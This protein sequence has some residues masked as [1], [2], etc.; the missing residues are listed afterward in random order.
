MW[1]TPC[2]RLRHARQARDS[3]HAAATPPPSA[4]AG[5]LPALQAFPR[6]RAL[7]A[8]RRAAGPGGGG[9]PLGRRAA[10]FGLLPGW[11]G[12]LLLGA[13]PGRVGRRRRRLRLGAG[14]A[15]GGGLHWVGLELGVGGVQR[16][17]AACV[18]VELARAPCGLEH[19]KHKKA[20]CVYVREHVRAM[21][22]VLVRASS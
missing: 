9:R 13:L 16:A 14:G 20:T 3:R 2:S 15:G 22:F 21:N 17:A 12:T 7:S 18:C 4:A 19:R 8:G 5:G 10:P 6:R 11:L 1:R